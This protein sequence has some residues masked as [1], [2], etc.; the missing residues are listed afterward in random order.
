MRISDWSS[1]VCSSDLPARSDRRSVLR[2]AVPHAAARPS[3]ARTAGLPAS[4]HALWSVCRHDRAGSA[5]PG[6]AAG[7]IVPKSRSPTK[8]RKS[9][10]WSFLETLCQIVPGQLR[11]RLLR[12]EEHTSELQ[13]LM[14]ISYD[15]FCL[16]KQNTEKKN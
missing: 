1:D 6:R 12:S 15:V 9:Q 8:F 2:A 5:L 3:R 7:R 11:G 13:S 14:R 16:K 10:P 4:G